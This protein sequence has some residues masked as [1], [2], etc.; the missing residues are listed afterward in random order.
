[1]N[2]KKSFI[3]GSTDLALLL[4]QH[5]QTVGDNPIAAFVVDDNLKTQNK[6]Y[7]IPVIG[8]SVIAQKLPPE[9]Y[10]CYICVGYSN[11]NNYR[12]KI[13][14]RLINLGYSLQQFIHPTAIINGKLLG[15]GNL[16]FQN[17]IIDFYTTVGNCNIFYPNTLIAHHSNIGNFNFFAVSSCVTGHVTIEDNNFIGAHATIGNNIKIPHHCLIGAGSYLSKDI[18]PYDVLVPQRS[19]ILSSKKSTHFFK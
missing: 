7:D 18:Q 5:L 3:F 2:K 8:T 11:M 16:I 1:M 4:Y 9:S 13:F 14:H 12:K 17:V 10:D 6:I 15:I 19:E